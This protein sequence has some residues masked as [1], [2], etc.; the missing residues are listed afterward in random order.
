[1]EIE[2]MYLWLLNKNSGVGDISL[3][4]LLYIQIVH[5][6]GPNPERRIVYLSRRRICKRLAV[7]IGACRTAV[8]QL[9][10]L[11]FIQPCDSKGNS[12]ED[13][14]SNWFILNPR[15]SLNKPRIQSIIE[16]INK[17]DSSSGGGSSG[18]A[19]SEGLFDK[20][21]QE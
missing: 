7:S 3:R 2:H 12:V 13:T 1:M 8:K 18:D 20:I 19:G 21:M 11:G 15:D 14:A 16:H 9:A 6:T 5:K 17:A 10:D 4:L